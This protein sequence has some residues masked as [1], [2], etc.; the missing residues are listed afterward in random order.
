KPRHE[1]D[2]TK[3][4]AG[5]GGSRSNVKTSRRGVQGREEARKLLR[6]ALFVPFS[7]RPSFFYVS[8]CRNLFT[9]ETKMARKPT[10]YEFIPKLGQLRDDVLFGDVWE[11]PD[12]KKRDRSLATVAILA[13]LY[14]T[15]EMRGHM[16]RALENG[17][18]E[19]ELKGLVT[20]VAFYAGWPC[21]VNACRVLIEVCSEK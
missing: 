18:T 7:R 20:H 21:A 12:L 4:D 14:R 2:D 11:H 19:T 1:H 6:F 5:G 10:V 13:A 17:V 3:Q 16:K 15:D 8:S 9:E